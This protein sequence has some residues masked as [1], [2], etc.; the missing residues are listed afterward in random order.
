MWRGSRA[1]HAQMISGPRR[2]TA[3]IFQGSTVPG[4]LHSPQ[5]LQVRLAGH[6]C[7]VHAVPDVLSSVCLTYLVVSATPAWAAREP[8]NAR[9]ARHAP[10]P[11]H[12]PSIFGRAFLGDL[13]LEVRRSAGLQ[14]DHR[15]PH[16]GSEPTSQ[17][18]YAE[19]GM[20]ECVVL[21]YSSTVKLC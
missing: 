12:G 2:R 20:P 14:V 4:W 13:Q 9:A 5:R 19:C 6:V 3:V 1:L 11:P 10:A 8:V 21:E 18:Y 16:R 17:I 15:L 7:A